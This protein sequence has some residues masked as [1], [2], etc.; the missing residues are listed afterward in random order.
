MDF[1]LAFGIV[2]KLFNVYL[3]GHLATPPVPQVPKNSE[4]FIFCKGISF[5]ST[6]TSFTLILQYFFW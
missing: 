6:D 2:H 4:K 1:E 5:L 3:K